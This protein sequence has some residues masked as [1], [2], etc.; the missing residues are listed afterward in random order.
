MLPTLQHLYSTVFQTG[1][2]KPDRH[3]ALV[4]AIMQPLWRPLW[5]P[6]NVSRRTKLQVFRPASVVSAPEQLAARLD[7]F[8]IRIEGVSWM[9]PTRQYG[10][11]SNNR[12][13]PN[14]TQKA[15]IWPLHLPTPGSPPRAVMGLMPNNWLEIISQ[16]CRSRINCMNICNNRENNLGFLYERSIFQYITEPINYLIMSPMGGAVVVSTVISHQQDPGFQRVPV[17]AWVLSGHTGFVSQSKD[18]S[19]WPRRT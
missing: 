15:L 5:W 3:G 1:A 18:W 16:A 7:G 17:S 14:D 6:Q 11:R 2:I 10:G 4:G 12:L 19:R 9:L 13:H 8:N